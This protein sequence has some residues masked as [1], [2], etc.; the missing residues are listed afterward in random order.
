[1]TES[2]AGTARLRVLHLITRMDLGGAQQNTLYTCAHLDPKRFEVL[3]VAGEGGPLDEELRAAL[4]DQ[5]RFLPS[6]KRELHPGYDLLAALQLIGLFLKEKPDIVHTHSSKA[7]ILGRLAAWAAGV[8]VIIHTFH[9]FGFHDYQHPFTKALYVAAERLAGKVSDRLIFV[10]RSNQSYAEKHA[11]GDPRRYE[12]IRSGVKLS[13]FP[14]PL[15]DKGRKK[16]SL[17]L[18]MHKPLVTS[19]GNL[20]PQKNPGDFIAA[21]GSVIAGG[22]DARFLFVGDGPLR[23]KLEYQII[24]SGLHGKLALPGWRRD[25]AEILAASDIFV[26]TSLWEGLPRALVEAMRTGLPPVCYATDGVSDLIKDGE[27][28]FLIPPGNV[29]LMAEKI[30]LLIKDEPLRLR[31]G[32]RARESITPDFDIDNMVRAQERLYEALAR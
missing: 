3:A 23:T 32:T 30:S 11:L 5:A 1:M 9:G 12:L 6:L 25:T 15:D 31:L 13:E 19:I 28:G 14:A 8:P 7:G 20:K 2:A 29:S 10:S 18:G 21:A 22:A 4:G 26:L 17:G 24:A 16:A 27:N